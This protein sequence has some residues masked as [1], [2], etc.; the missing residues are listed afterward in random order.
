LQNG[1][2][3]LHSLTILVY[4]FGGLLACL[5]A[6]SFEYNDFLSGETSDPNFYFGAFTALSTIVLVASFFLNPINEPE[7]IRMSEEDR[8]L[9]HGSDELAVNCSQTFSEI[10]RL[11]GYREFLLPVLFFVLQ[12]FLLPNLDDL[13]YIFLIE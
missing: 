4:A 6:G 11:S 12:G 7:I 9:L 8:K 10:C 13:H 2:A 3:N 1:S 5:M